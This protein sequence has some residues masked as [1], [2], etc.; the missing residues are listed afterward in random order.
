[1]TVPAEPRS[2]LAPIS[3]FSSNLSTLLVMPVTVT[4]VPTPE[5]ILLAWLAVFAV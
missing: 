1:M 5:V 4:P 3:D 2:E